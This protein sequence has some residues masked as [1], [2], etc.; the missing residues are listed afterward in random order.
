MVGGV[1]V[2]L[3]AQAL[4]VVGVTATDAA[5]ESA[6]ARNK[7]ARGKAAPLEPN[8]I[9][10]KAAD[11]YIQHSSAGRKLRF[12]S[13]L[14][15]IGRGPIEVR[16]NQNRP[17]PDG[18]HHA[19]QVLY[20]DV[21]GNRRYRR[22]VDTDLARRSAG[23]MVFHPYHDHWHFEAASRYTLWKKNAQEPLRVGHRKMSFCLRDSREVPDSYGTFNYPEHYGACSRY[24]P[25]GISIGWVDVYQSYLAGQALKLPARA[26]DGLYC[27]QIKVDPTDA[28]RESDDADNTSLRAFRLSGDRI[29]VVPTSRCR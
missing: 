19:T 24:S 25:Q 17:C 22:D 1:L 20:R 7:A 14:G 11:L 18:Q 5:T 26:G 10:L 8:L 6:A 27:L 3:V 29:R 12:E 13:G 23:C 28:I 9:A 16:P 2:V 21:D 15:N 4:A